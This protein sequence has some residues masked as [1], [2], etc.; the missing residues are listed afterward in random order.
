MKIAL[1][2]ASLI[3]L[4]AVLVREQWQKHGPRVAAAILIEGCP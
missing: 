4:V 2:Y 3:V 1:A